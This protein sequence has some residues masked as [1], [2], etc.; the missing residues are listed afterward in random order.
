[1]TQTLDIETPQATREHAL[2]YAEL[3]G[4]GVQETER[5][6]EPFL[7]ELRRMTPRE[8]IEASRYTMKPLGA[9]D[10]RRSLPRRGADGERRAGVDRP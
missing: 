10:L 6:L 9:L 2:T 1:M 7:S 5:L 3:R 8:R 4:R